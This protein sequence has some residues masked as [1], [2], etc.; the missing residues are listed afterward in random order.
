MKKGIQFYK[1][2]MNRKGN[3][4]VK[5]GAADPFI[6]KFNGYYY[7]ICT[8][9]KGLV[10]QKSLDLIHWEYVHGDGIV[11][12]DEYLKY[13]FA[14]ELSYDNGY[15]YIVSSP[16]GNGHRFYRST[17]LEGPYEAW[18]G[19]VQE[20]IDGSFF[21]DS[22]EKRY[23]LRASE[24]GIT[25]KRFKETEEKTDFDLFDEYYNFSESSIGNWTEGP[26]LLKRYGIYYLTYTGTHFLSNAY[27]VDY[28]S[29]KKLC[30]DGL[31]F[32][33]TLLISTTEQFYGLGHSMTFLGP[34]LDSYYLAYHNMMP[35]G[36]RYLNI[37]RL[38]FDSY[39]QMLCNGISIERNIQW[40]RPYFEER[41]QS[42]NYLS[43]ERMANQKFS[44]EYNFLGK[45]VQLIISYENEEDYQY[46]QMFEDHIDVIKK[47]SDKENVIFSQ[48]LNKTYRL[49]VFHSIRL[50]YAKGRL[51]IY[52]DDMEIA[53]KKKVKI[54]EGKIGFYNNQL[55]D[56]YL[57]YSIHAY[58]SSDQETMKK[59]NFFL[60]N[61]LKK[62]K[63]YETT[64]LVDNSL[65]YDVFLSSEK[66]Q[67]LQLQI[68]QQK[69]S[70]DLHKGKNYISTV[71]LKKGKHR[72]SFFNIQPTKEIFTIKEHDYPVAVLKH[73]RFLKQADIYYRYL[74]MENGFYFEN[75]RNAILTKE[76]YLFYELEAQITLV[77]NPTKTDRFI[78]LVSDVSHY[79]KTNEFENAYSFMGWMF[80]LNH[81]EFQ[82]I[83]TNYDHSK[84]VWKK[85]KPKEDIFILKI[86]K[87]EKKLLFYLNEQLV[88][89]TEDIFR[90]LPGQLGMMNNHASGIFRN[91][92]FINLEIKEGAR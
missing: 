84:V 72:I 21:K 9:E 8:K 7:L 75:D 54:E 74:P 27:R 38:M 20:L 28:S 77:G 58:G 17:S 47:E 10:L 26:Y 82:I 52:L 57:A 85:K 81:N 68:D 34:D 24:S 2:I 41:I 49:D 64:L 14:P 18:H 70:I 78:G 40:E 53:L 44:S 56:A 83:D 65:D 29:G 61:T 22:D 69:F 35:N 59:E 25:I 48:K 36:N 79:G 89:E 76:N 87:E 43:L 19:N 51:T 71:F 91:Y 80:V 13:A 33:D 45:D 11:A 60:A 30:R 15:F 63:G 3:G 73:D 31:K 37:T 55:G 6:Y 62:K 39:G 67:T 16:S 88:Y 42:P 23:F 5:E 46:L 4:G 50:Q 90:H 66:E 12:E 32:Q 86:R 92:H 1:N